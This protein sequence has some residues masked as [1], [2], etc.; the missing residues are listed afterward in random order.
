MNKLSLRFFNVYHHIFGEH[1]N[2]RIDY[3]FPSNVMRWDLVKEVIKR[4]NYKRYLEIGCDT[5]LLFSKIPDLN[6]KIGVD[7]ISGGNYRGTSDEFFKQNKNYFDCIFIDG[8]HTYKQVKN[9]ILNSIKF[10]NEDGVILVHDC[11]PANFYQQ[12]VPRCKMLWTGDVWKSIVELRTKDN[13]DVCVC[14]IDM[15]VGIIKKRKNSKKLE[16]NCSDFSKLKYKEYYA[17]YANFMRII[18][19]EDIFNFLNA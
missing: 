7:P 3:K 5:D 9:D 18:S 19:Y 2:K 6:I 14:R 10:L 1:F 4:K 8:L 17:N 12:A 16:F 15:G 11:L 13:I